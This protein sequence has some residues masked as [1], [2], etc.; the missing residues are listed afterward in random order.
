MYFSIFITHLVFRFG[1]YTLTVT[2]RWASPF[3]I[4]WPAHCRDRILSNFRCVTLNQLCGTYK[5]GIVTRGEQQAFSLSRS[6]FYALRWRTTWISK[7]NNIVS[8]LRIDRFKNKHPTEETSVKN[9]TTHTCIWKGWR[10]KGNV[11]TIVR[12]WRKITFLLREKNH[13]KKRQIT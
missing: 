10:K 3:K 6:N 8:E 11:V 1:W 4:T 9:T 13:R 7:N 12:V 2:D 5:S